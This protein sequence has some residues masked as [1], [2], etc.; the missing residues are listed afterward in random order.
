MA[1]TVS[2]LPMAL[3]LFLVFSDS[4]IVSFGTRNNNARLLISADTTDHEFCA[5][6]PGG[7]QQLKI[8][9][10]ENLARH[11]R[12]RTVRQENFRSFLKNVVSFRCC[13][14]IDFHIC[15]HD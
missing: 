6:A 5:S 15:E 1:I 2:V 14:H 11:C 8:L 7:A 12:Q 9:P 3:L 10:A 13:S 4:F